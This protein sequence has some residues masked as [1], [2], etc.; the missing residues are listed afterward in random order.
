MCIRD[1]ICN[2]L[3]AFLRKLRYLTKRFCG[4]LCYIRAVIHRLY[5]RSYQITGA[6]CEFCRLGR[7]IPYLVRYDR[8]SLACLACP[9]G[10]DSRIECEYVGL[11]C[12]ILNGRDNL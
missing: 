8:K 6:V 12:N 3:C 2:E 10:L 7:K 9:G 11:E 4:L 5:G 1:S